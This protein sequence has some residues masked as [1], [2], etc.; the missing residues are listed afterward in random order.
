MINS[1]TLSLISLPVHVWC[2]HLPSFI[3]WLEEQGHLRAPAKVHSF[4]SM[5]LLIFWEADG[6]NKNWTHHTHPLPKQ[7]QS[8]TTC[9]NPKKMN[10]IIHAFLS[11]IVPILAVEKHHLKAQWETCVG[12][13]DMAG[14]ECEG[15]GGGGVGGRGVGALHHNTCF[16]LQA[17]WETGLQPSP[18]T[19]PHAEICS[20][21]F[22]SAGMTSNC[23]SVFCTVKTSDTQVAAAGESL[24]R[25]ALFQHFRDFFIMY[26]LQRLSLNYSHYNLK[27]MLKNGSPNKLCHF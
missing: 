3:Y 17:I 15:G 18:E 22:R 4:F 14:V 13:C 26:T 11:V 20:F 5:S 12:T 27:R 2:S 10:H 16:I 1:F 8:N 25:L 21:F 9:W 23:F 24:F 6:C 7:T 19:W